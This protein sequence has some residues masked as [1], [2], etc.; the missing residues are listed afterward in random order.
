M[1]ATRCSEKSADFQQI[2]HRYIPEDEPLY[3]HRCENLKP[4]L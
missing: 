1:E 3:N 2:T 4:Y